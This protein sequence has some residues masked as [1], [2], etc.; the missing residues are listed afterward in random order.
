M[1]PERHQDPDRL[2]TL[3]HCVKTKNTYTQGRTSRNDGNSTVAVRSTTA[4]RTRQAGGSVKSR[5]GDPEYVWR[6]MIDAGLGGGIIM[7][8]AL[9]AL[10]VHHSG[11]GS[12]WAKRVIQLGTEAG[13]WDA[14]DGRTRAHRMLNRHPDGTELRVRT[15]KERAKISHRMG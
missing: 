4:L 12:R 13:C 11:C 6:L 7:R 2:I 5:L 14:P 9:E 8:A 15:V 1:N 3:V 10:I